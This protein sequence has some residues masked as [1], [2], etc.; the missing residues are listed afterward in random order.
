MQRIPLLGYVHVPLNPANPQSLAQG[1]YA[2]E[3]EAGEDQTAAHS[4]GLVKKQHTTPTGVRH[5]FCEGL[6]KPTDTARLDGTKQA[7]NLWFKPAAAA[8]YTET[9]LNASAPTEFSRAL[10]TQPLPTHS[11]EGDPCP[12]TQTHNLSITTSTALCQGFLLNA[13][14]QPFSTF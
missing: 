9:D 10:L 11:T 13:N 8:C 3:R 14:L 7:P 1:Y 2:G 12:T 4:F 6:T 5:K